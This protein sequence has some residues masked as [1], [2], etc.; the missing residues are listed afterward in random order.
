MTVS[1]ATDQAVEQ[2]KSSAR[3]G[4]EYSWN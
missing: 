3:S 2:K 4:V 1:M